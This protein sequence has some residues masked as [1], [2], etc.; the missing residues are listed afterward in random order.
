MAEVAFSS[1]TSVAGVAH[2]CGRRRPRKVA[3]FQ[4]NEVGFVVMI[5]AL[6]IAELAEYSS[7]TSVAGFAHKCGR[8]RP[9]KVAGF[10]CNEVGFVVMIVA[11]AIADRKSVV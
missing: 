9:L 2:K 11:L 5:V 8:R 10:Q 1:P 3:G 4:C 7:P 6:A